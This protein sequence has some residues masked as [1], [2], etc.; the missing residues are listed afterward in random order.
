MI[1]RLILF[2][3]I[4]QLV[5]NILKYQHVPVWKEFQNSEELFLQRNTGRMFQVT[6]RTLLIQRPL[7]PLPASVIR[8]RTNIS[9]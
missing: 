4:I 2:F 1:E 9:M 5:E 7:R 8:S 3:Y 6:C